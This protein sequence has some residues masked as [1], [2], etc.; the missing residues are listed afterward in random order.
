M[1]S[2]RRILVGLDLGSLGR[3]LTPGSRA[4]LAQALWLAGETGARVTLFHSS[5]RDEYFD[6]DAGWTIVHEGLSEE[7]RASLDAA[8]A[9]LRQEGLRTELVV[10]EERAAPALLERI[11]QEG[12]ELVVVGK[13]STDVHDGRALGTLAR[14]M[15]G[16]AP[17]D[18]WVVRAGAEPPPRTILAACD[19][20]PVG[21]RLLETGAWL[22]AEGGG[23]LHVLHACQSS[24]AV[25]MDPDR[26]ELER[27]L[28]AS[29]RKELEE[30][31]SQSGIE[32]RAQFHVGITS[33]THAVLEAEERLRPDLVLIGR[34]S[35]AGLAGLLLGNTAERL[36]SR[37]ETSMLG[38]RPPAEP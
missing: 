2:L 1:K 3:E 6:G 38:V 19:L 26:E 20:D 15:F 13:R 37:L 33:P 8:A 10:S 22:A 18:V 24:V 21:R 30:W 29:A 31:L 25:Q 4:A 14:R 5:A 28:V 23:E 16:I 7:G 32:C 9:S 27:E 11:E 12:A 36:L 17:C 35:R 34:V